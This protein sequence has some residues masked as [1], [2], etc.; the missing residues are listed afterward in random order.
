MSDVA[1][2]RWAIASAAAL[3]FVL[4]IALAFQLGRAASPAGPLGAGAGEMGAAPT[5]PTPLAPPTSPP[6]VAPSIA[7]PPPAAPEPPPI[8]APLT[9]PVPEQARPD[10]EREAVRNYLAT[11]EL[12]LASAKDFE[13]ANKTAL[14]TLQDLSGTGVRAMRDDQVRLRARVAQIDAPQPC[15]EYRAALLR[16]LDQGVAMLDKLATSMSAGDTA[17]LTEVAAEGREIEAAA[18]RVDQLAMAIKK[19]YAL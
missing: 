19:Q 6:P 2:P 11:I 13:D 14:Q 9:A 16:S 17:K 12:E 15:L 5:S 18:R 3:I 8:A 4:A 7:D 1:V 10:A